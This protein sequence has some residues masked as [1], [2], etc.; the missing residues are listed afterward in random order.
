LTQAEGETT[1]HVGEVS[2][3]KRIL[4]V[5]LIM[6]A[7]PLL[8]PVFVLVALY[9]KV[10]SRGPVFYTQE[11]V[12]YRGHRFRMFKFRSM[13]LDAEAS[14][15]HA[16][17]THLFRS[18]QPMEKLDHVDPRLIPFAWLMRSTGLD[19]LPQLINVLRGEMSL[20]GPRPCTIYVH[21]VMLTWHK[22]R[23]SVLPGVTGL[24]Q[25]NGKNQTTFLEMMNYDVEYARRWSLWLDLKIILA[26]FPALSSQVG[27]ILEKRREARNGGRGKAVAVAA[28][29]G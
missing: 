28:K 13:R 5:G 10:V 23:F 15:H 9:I 3:G 27:E 12:G 22:R 4:D 2:L 6:L 20:V 8:L 14:L 11:R 17:T 1:W 26:T 24:W 18:N 16:H 29:E 19:E 21:E 25:V 7:L